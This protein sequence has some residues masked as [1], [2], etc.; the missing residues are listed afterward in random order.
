MYSKFKELFKLE[1]TRLAGASEELA[2]ALDILLGK[3]PSA[4]VGRAI[5]RRL[6]VEY[7]TKLRDRHDIAFPDYVDELRVRFSSQGAQV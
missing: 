1:P 7:G 2:S 4:V 6:A 3:I 5:M